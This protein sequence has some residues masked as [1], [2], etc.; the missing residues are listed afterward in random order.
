MA[1][2]HH[3]LMSHV[4]DMLMAD[5]RLPVDGPSAS[6]QHAA[7]VNARWID[8]LPRNFLSHHVRSPPPAIARPLP[9]IT[10]L[11]PP[12]RGPGT[13]C[14]IKHLGQSMHFVLPP[15]MTER[16]RMPFSEVLPVAR[17]QPLIRPFSWH[18]MVPWT[19]QRKG[20]APPPAIASDDAVIRSIVRGMI[21]TVI[22]REREEAARQRAARKAAAQ[23]EEVRKVVQ[24]L[25]RRTEQEHA[26]DLKREREVAAVVRRLVNAVVGPAGSTVLSEEARREREVAVVVRR[27]ISRVEAACGGFSDPRYEQEQIGRLDDYLASLPGGSHGLVAGWT[28]RVDVR[29]SGG[30]AGETD[31]YFF[32]EHGKKFRSKA[33]V[34]RHMLLAPPERAVRRGGSTGLLA[35]TH[36]TPERVVEPAS[37]QVVERLDDDLDEVEEFV[38]VDVDVESVG[39]AAESDAMLVEDVVI[40][41]VGWAVPA[42]TATAI[43]GTDGGGF[44]LNDDND[45]DDDEVIEVDVE[46]IGQCASLPL[47]NENDVIRETGEC[48]TD[49][50][51]DECL[52]TVERLELQCALSHARLTDPAKGS[53]CKHAAL[54]NYDT[55]RSYVGRWTGATAGG[56]ACPIAGCSARLQ[57]TRGVE[58]DEA[59]AKQIAA[60]PQSVITVW[61]CTRTG[62][63]TSVPPELARQRVALGKRK[64][65]HDQGVG[66]RG[67]LDLALTSSTRS[68][69]GVRRTSARGMEVF[70]EEID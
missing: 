13:H 49:V 66:D 25:I 65:R 46:M 60:L 21:N 28:I 3:H 55:L 17:A 33:E 41:N 47:E 29:Q 18:A 34:A 20:S 7:E 27:L 62:R 63:L 40:A 26:A 52:V 23:Q 56:K 59:L 10:V 9:A 12:N 51:G 14:K 32:D 37:Q 15:T 68:A 6:A 30:T 16:D 57:R 31:L 69:G 39:D 70:I 44:A 67:R 24:R 22:M 43:D 38:E 19:T 50:E 58:R 45:D 11:I 61:R 8:P 48:S 5:E 4:F 1:T 36:S 42:S 64:R 53:A 54:C 2:S 35:L